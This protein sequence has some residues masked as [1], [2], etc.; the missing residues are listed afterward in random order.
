MIFVLT[1]NAIIIFI[2]Y[3]Y[4]YSMESKYLLVFIRNNVCI[5]LDLF[6]LNYILIVFIETVFIHI[7]WIG[8][9]FLLFNTCIYKFC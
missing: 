9:N 8:S 1:T 2:L 4:M 5:E 3:F 7:Y 6:I